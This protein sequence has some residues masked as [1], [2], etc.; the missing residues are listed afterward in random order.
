MIGIV[1]HGA[2]I[3]IYRLSRDVIAQNWGTGAMRGERSVAN[4]DEDSITMA[5]E[6]GANCIEGMDRESIDRLYFASTTSPHREKQSA[7][8]VAAAL[9]L[10]EEVVT[11]DFGNSLRAGINALGC[12]VDAVKA[13]SAKKVLV[14]ASD[15][16]IAP[17]NS[18]FEPVFGDGA[19]ALLVGDSDVAVEVQE[20]LSISSPFFDIWRREQDTYVHSWEERF[21]TEEGYL[22][23]LPR[24]ASAAMKKARL[25]SKDFAKLV[26][27]GPDAR[28]HR[29]VARGLGFDDKTQV[30]DPLFGTIGNTG[31]AHALMMLAAALEEAKGRERF[32]LLGYGD[33]CDAYV[34]ET[35]DGIERLKNKRGVAKHIASKRMLTNYGKYLRFR[36]IVEEE[37]QVPP[38][39]QPTDV[40]LSWR[41]HNQLLSFHGGKCNQCGHI[42]FPINRV[43]AWCQAK[44]DYQEIRMSDKKGKLFTY[45]TNRLLAPTPDPPAI[46]SLV[47]F[48]GGG[49]FWSMMADAD[50]EKL[51]IGMPME[52]T[53]R[54]IHTERAFNNYFWKIRP[55][56]C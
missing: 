19:A 16:R 52:M 40:T 36:H 49:R 35:K 13:G 8:I 2:Y 18:A 15:C 26:H 43:C 25:G 20:S 44:D 33:G 1:S 39:P 29:Q 10:G 55:V 38:P 48:D 42:Q 31:A 37:Q 4:Y 5:V 12:A 17:P 51:E 45:S 27:Y 6:A 3:P 24:A 47:D 41:E 53:F 7:S 30:Q 32:L 21:V 54:V 9:D 56:R 23:I 34:L 11:A 28:R 14:I 50:M 22:K 46:L